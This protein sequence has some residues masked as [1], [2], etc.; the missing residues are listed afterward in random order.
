[1]KMAYFSVM[2]KSCIITG[3]EG[4]IGTGSPITPSFEMTRYVT[5]GRE[6]SWIWQPKV[7]SSPTV[8]NVFI[9]FLASTVSCS[10]RVRSTKHHDCIL[11]MNNLMNG[12]KPLEEAAETQRKKT[13]VRVELWVCSERM[14]K[15]LIK[16]QAVDRLQITVLEYPYNIC[17]DVISPP[18][19]T[20]FC[21]HPESFSK[22]HSFV[23]IRCCF[24]P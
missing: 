6:G 18:L 14:I 11:G 9:R 13:C 22:R 10:D 24:R 1:M 20:G 21:T 23:G 3:P 7:N 4:V 16:I 12:C 5:Y 17:N 19:E 15:L 8:D 2:A